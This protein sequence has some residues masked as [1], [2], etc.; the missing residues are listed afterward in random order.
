MKITKPIQ[1]VINKQITSE[2]TAEHNYLSLAAHFEHIKLRGF[3]SW[4]IKQAAEEKDH[5]L[6]LFNYINDRDGEVTLQTIPAPKT[7]WG[8]IQEAFQNVLEQEQNNTVQIHKLA[9]SAK[10]DNDKATEVFLN[11]FVTEQIEEEASAREILDKVTMAKDNAAAL[12]IL[13][14]ELGKRES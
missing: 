14:S 9:N 4:M 1:D 3:A 8:S 6:K 12:M 5:A 2:L 10:D 13:D 11:W 7:N